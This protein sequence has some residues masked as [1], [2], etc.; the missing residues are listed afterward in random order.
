MKTIRILCFLSAV[1]FF[2]SCQEETKTLFRLLP[3]TKT[4]VDFINTIEETDSF[5][6]L[7]EEY[8][9]NGGGVGVGDFDNDGLEDLFF[10][11]NLVSNKLYINQGNLKFKD[12]TDVAK[13]T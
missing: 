11:G 3:P 10:T 9:Y 6:I 8:I 2:V 1:A 12:V 7:T 4:G 5:N 13:L